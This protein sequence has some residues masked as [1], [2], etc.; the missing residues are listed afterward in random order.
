MTAAIWSGSKNPVRAFET[1]TCGMGGTAEWTLTETGWGA[2]ADRAQFLA[3]FPEGLPLDPNEPANVARIAANSQLRL[4]A[5]EL[6]D[7]ADAIECGAEAGICH[8]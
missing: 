1:R 2:R 8:G 3:V 7:M 5:A 4:W 6:N